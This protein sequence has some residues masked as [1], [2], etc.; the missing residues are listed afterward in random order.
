MSKYLILGFL[1]MLLLPA[2]AIGDG[3]IC[4]P[5][6]AKCKAGDVIK[7]SGHQ[8]AKK[9]DFGKAI[10]IVKGDS[11]QSFCVYLGYEREKR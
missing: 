6:S 4:F 11:S 3:K 10:A 1:G 2:M 9:C 8:I 5:F 7:V